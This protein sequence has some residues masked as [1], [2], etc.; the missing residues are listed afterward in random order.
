MGGST[1]SVTQNV[2]SE[3]HEKRSVARAD[4]ED[5]EPSWATGVDAVDERE[6][7]LPAIGST[8]W[9]LKRWTS[10]GEKDARG[11]ARSLANLGRQRVPDRA[12]VRKV[13]PPGNELTCFQVTDY[14]FRR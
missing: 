5:C 14:D 2:A 11:G 3:P 4:R 10:L 1:G 6:R 8:G 13:P 12:P 7:R 9:T